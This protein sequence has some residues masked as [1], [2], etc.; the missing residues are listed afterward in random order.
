MMSAKIFTT[1]MTVMLLSAGLSPEVDA[2][3]DKTAGWM[4][5]VVSETGTGL[6]LQWYN[7]F[8]AQLNELDQRLDDVESSISYAE[9]LAPT[10]Q[11]VMDDSLVNV[12]TKL[13]DAN[14]LLGSMNLPPPPNDTFVAFATGEGSVSYDASSTDTIK[15]QP[16]V[17]NTQHYDHD[18]GTFTAPR[19]G[20]YW[21]LLRATPA[22][23]IHIDML[24]NG[25]DQ[26]TQS[27]N[28]VS[29]LK[30]MHLR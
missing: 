8:S 27:S 17:V 10:L 24:R 28:S 12:T 16:P 4:T 29:R 1:L 6:V 7:T 20:L 21:F 25:V 30:A 13:A 18:T 26:L 9:Q 14:T 2:N 15:L 22:S 11:Q 23:S 5:D 3:E 19:D